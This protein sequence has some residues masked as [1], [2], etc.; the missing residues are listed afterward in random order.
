MTPPWIPLLACLTYLLTGTPAQTAF[1]AT[2][3]P[4]TLMES[5]ASRQIAALKANSGWDCLTGWFKNS[6]RETF[7]KF[8]KAIYTD[9]PQVVLMTAD[10][11]HPIAPGES[12]DAVL[13]NREWV[14]LVKQ[15]YSYGT[16]LD[17]L[18]ERHQ[19]R[20]SFT[21][22]ENVLMLKSLHKRAAD[23]MFLAPEEAEGTIAASG[24][25]PAQFKLIR[26]SKMPKGVSR[27]IMCSKNVP[28]AVIARLNTAIK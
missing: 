7:A 22:D 12:I 24:F 14:M 2:E 15:S 27:H 11:P 18:I 16:E 19:P 23:Y 20:R 3:V 17:A 4:F 5:S 21:T 28:E 6:E 8:T 9:H 10:H 1:K 26:L 13:R 25:A